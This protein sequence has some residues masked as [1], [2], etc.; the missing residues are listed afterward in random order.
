[1]KQLLIL[2]FLI[3]PSITFATWEINSQTWSLENNSQNINYNID[4]NTQ[5][6]KQ[7]K[8]EISINSDY[9]IDLTDLYENLTI[10]NP[11][12]KF[13]FDWNL[14][15]ASSQS[16]TVFKRNFS[17]K[18]EKELELS[19]FELSKITDEN[20]NENFDSKLLFNKVFE[21]LVYEKSFFLVYSD[22]VDES[23]INNYIDFSK[24]DGIFINTLWPLN[25]TDIEL[26]SIINSIDKYEK[27]WWLKSD[28]IIVWWSRDFVFNV[29]SNINKNIALNEDFNKT[30]NIISISWYNIDI[31]W[32]YL[33]NFLSNKS[34]INKL[35]ILNENSKYLILKQN[36]IADLEKELS[37]NKHDF[38]DVNLTNNDVNNFFFVSKF[39]NNL[40][41]LWYSTNSIYMFLIIP[42]VLTA[43]IFFKHFIWI[44]PIWIAIPLFIT[45]LFFKLW[46]FVTLFLI[47]FYVS[48]NL[49]LSM[50]TDRYNLLYAPKMVFLITINIITFVLFINIWYWF[51]I[52]W[53]NASDMLYFI[54][55]ILLS[56]KM[57]NI[58]ISKDLLEYKESF[59]Y[60]ILISLFCFWILSINAIKIITLSYPEIILWLIPINFLI[61]KFSWLRVTE[62][63]RF[64]EI[65]KSIEE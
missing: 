29:L 40:S 5:I 38:I 30:L 22:E 62:Y 31:L 32:S 48:L 42:F 49:F 63:F 37:E 33:K 23:D 41:N 8:K 21:I 17:E 34:W 16:W 60:T 58:I 24:K 50:I 10:L 15:W 52:I 39:I 59:F 3:L 1:M 4:L 26:T 45:L 55:F 47:I 20:W 65:I 25:K 51:W 12:K 35:I 56:E 53:L 19:I 46:V 18:W 9:V 61:W 27:L 14:K 36:L 43:V 2:I 57:I 64:K 13:L 44:S 6:E 28:F 11:E 54:I 7:Y